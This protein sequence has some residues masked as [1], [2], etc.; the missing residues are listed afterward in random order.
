MV[1]R[2][3]I[4]I[5]ENQKINSNI[6]W[7]NIGQVV[8]QISHLY[9]IVKESHVDL[10]LVDESHP[11]LKKPVSTRIRRF[12]G[13]TE[14][15]KIIETDMVNE[16][17]EEY[18]EGSI[19]IE[20]GEKGILKKI[21]NI[22]HAKGLLEEYHIVSRSSRMKAIAE[23]IERIAPAN[24]AVLIVGAS[25][26]GKELVARAIHNHSKR[27]SQ[28]F[29]AVNCGAISEGILE[30]ELF[31]HEKG[32]FTGSITKREGLFHKADGGTV[33]LD[34]IGE[35]LPA[36]QVKLLR[37]LEDGTYYPVGSSEAQ[38]V[39]VRL[40][41]ATNR[42]LGEAISENLFRE[43]LYFRIGVVKIVLPP[44]M[45]RIGDIQP[46]LRFFWKNNPKLDYTDSTLDLLMKYNW[47]GN[48]RQL[49]NFTDRMIALKPDG[50]LVE[51]ADVKS[52]LDEQNTAA[53]HLP[54]ATGKT[55]DEAG[56]E[57]IYRA[58]ISLGNEIKMLRDLLLSH[59]PA[60]ASI[61]DIQGGSD[62]VDDSKSMEDMEYKLIEKIL[63]ET[64][65]NRKETAKQLGIGERT[66]YRKLKK[67]NLR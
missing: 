27:S 53:T 41:S 14:I 67:Y 21:E 11:E 8:T 46:L 62:L 35:T 39:D 60:D 23:T 6:K 1:N 36:M 13:L 17:E 51:V 54:V 43:D 45:D 55:A 25:G 24:V 2:V 26:T 56:Q 64:G 40:V 44:L 47:P 50:G 12:N 31:G 16:P 49:K 65:G 66:L 59:L 7:S 48:I 9:Q 29:V 15:W 20:L 19:S 58:I 37:V 42:D 30:S 28:P 4:L 61:D 5:S 18:I 57:L 34:E 38:K 32:A 52:F 22:L 63:E 33:L 3:V 10:I